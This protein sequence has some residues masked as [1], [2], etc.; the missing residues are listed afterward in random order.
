MVR[1]LKTKLL[2]SVFLMFSVCFPF[3]A[4]GSENGIVIEPLMEGA[5]MAAHAVESYWTAE[6]LA[7]AKPMPTP[8]IIVDPSSLEF[9]LIME[10]DSEQAL[11]GYSPGCSPANAS[12]CTNKIY[13]LSPDSPL[14]SASAA[15]GDLIQPLHGTKPTNPKDGPYGPFQRWSEAAPITAFPKSTMGKLFFTLNNANYVCSAT[16]IGRS[17]VVTAGHCN[18]DGKGHMAT[19][20]LFCPSY[21]DAA[22]A[23]R[24]CWAVTTS[25]VSSRWHTLGDPDYDY[26]CL[27]TN[28]TGTVVANKI[29]NV[30]GW[31]GRAWN[32]AP[33]QAERTFGY[34][35]EAPF[36]GKRLMTTASTEW[37]TQDFVAGGQVSK[38]IGSDLTG[39]CSGG[40]WVLGWTGAATGEIAD[41]DGSSA[42]DPGSNWVNGVNSHKRCLVNCNT[43]PT[44]TNGVFWQEMTSP[45]FKKTTAIG[46]SE[47]VI[48]ACLSHAN[49]N[50]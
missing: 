26:A 20:R 16:V 5:D 50:P 7:S 44:T 11:P 21:Q 38:I 34:P 37:Y 30:T 19:N 47:D 31:M 3:A 23:A 2:M 8:T 48:G 24:G 25:V 49:N 36:N 13:T 35:A 39:G 28:T 33:S 18:S 46:E 45:P 14:F 29:G 41:T 17:T 43:P 22:S 42:T 15:Y 12:K 6:L 40:S 32:F 10:Q 9:P 4:I 1:H 27:V